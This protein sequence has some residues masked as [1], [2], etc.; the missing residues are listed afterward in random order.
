MMRCKN[1]DVDI[2]QLLG[3]RTFDL[4]K[5]TDMDEHFLDFEES[6]HGHGHGHGHGA[7][8]AEEE[9]HSHGHS[10][11]HS[12]G[13]SKA[14]WDDRVSSVGIKEDG[15]LDLGKLN[16]WFGTLL[17][18][19]GADIFRM[20]GVLNINGQDE[21]FVFQGVHM[22][23][24]GQP[25]E[26]WGPDEKRCNKLVFIGKELDRKELTEAFLLCVAK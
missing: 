26:P 10:H 19:R 9:G 21:K 14:H 11:A 5:I 22:V 4:K 13:S 8:E 17:R 16:Q 12:H 6:G 7:A 20:K 18:D 2:K 15:A 1:C 23:F 3:L 25:M 24:D